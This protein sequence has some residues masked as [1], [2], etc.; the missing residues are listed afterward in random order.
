LQPGQQHLTAQLPELQDSY[1]VH[2][3][4]C[5]TNNGNI[6]KLLQPKK[7][8][9]HEIVP[10]VI[11]VPQAPI[12]KHQMNDQSKNNHVMAKGG[13]ARQMSKTFSQSGLESQLCKQRLNDHQTCKR[14]EPLVLESKLRNFV[15]TTGDLCFTIP[16]YQWPP[17]SVDFVAHHFNFNQSGGRF[18]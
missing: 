7:A 11:H 2:S 10:I 8:K 4:Q 6:G 5:P 9:H 18:A 1:G 14:R 12:A 16:H 3:R 13:V 15:D 17:G